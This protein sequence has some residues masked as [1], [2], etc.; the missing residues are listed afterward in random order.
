MKINFTENENKIDILKRP[1]LRIAGGWVRDKLLG[2]ESNDI[3]VV[4]DNMMGYDFA[5]LVREYM[6]NNNLEVSHMAR[7]AANPEK[8]K[9]ME[10]ATG[11]VLGQSIDFVNLSGDTPT[12]I[13]STE[14]NKYSINYGTPTG[15]HDLKEKI[16][17]T[18][19]PPYETFNDDPLR[20]L[21]VVRFASHFG[22]TIE[23]NVL[24]AIK[25]EEIQNMLSTRT[26]RSKIGEELNK[27]LNGNDSLKACEYLYDLNLYKIVFVR[28]PENAVVTIR[29]AL[30]KA[31][32]KEIQD[33]IQK[34][35][36]D[37][38]E[39]MAIEKSRRNKRRM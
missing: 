16:I 6:L 36:K 31:Q 7:V 39:D 20:T 33:Q 11:K 13:G 37:K 15:L 34:K 30:S 32:V 8:N 18:P 26:S 22:H 21:R 4:V 10:T 17:R 29:S 2:L 3:D 1:T 14:P 5:L 28:P 12:V 23:K 9:N 35:S 38:K 25:N 19:L 27:M 24:E